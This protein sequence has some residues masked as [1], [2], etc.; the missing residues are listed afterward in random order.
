LNYEIHPLH[1]G[2]LTIWPPFLAAPMAGYT[3]PLYRE[4]LREFGCP[5]C[6]TE[7]I[8]SKGLIQKGPNTLR[9]LDHSEADRPLA[10]QIFG[11]DPEE[12]FRAVRIVCDSGASFE[13]VDINMG[14][15]ARK[16]T[17]QGA[18]GALL[19]DV[20][21]ACEIVE[22]VKSASVVPVSVK[23]RTGWD[24]HE[25]AVDIAERLSSSGAD[26]LV[27]HGRTVTQGYGGTADWSVISEI[28]SSLD[29]PVVGNGDIQ[30]P[31]EG[32]ARLVGSG[33]SAVMVGR[34]TLGNPFF[35]RQL[36][37]IVEAKTAYRPT[38]VERIEAAQDHLRRAIAANGEGYALKDLKKHLGFY[39]KGMRGAPAARERISRASSLDEIVTAIEQISSSK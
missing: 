18:G 17:S 30:S 36:H 28:A 22:A 4:I 9:L 25:D 20:S 1:F 19:K 35:W 21:R 3:D 10:V 12:M 6:Y 14:C 15:P 37:L 2:N 38:N 31:E 11:E 24:K 16:I 29:V 32:L 7:M 13:S 27:V 23:M 33:C 8:S 39:F 5:Y 34:G 26:M